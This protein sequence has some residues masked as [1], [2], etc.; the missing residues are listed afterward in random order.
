MKKTLLWSCSA[1][2]LAA[3]V[4]YA[5]GIKLNTEMDKV[6]H[7]IG[8]NIGTNLN[9][10]EDLNV[11]VLLESIKQAREGKKLQL[12]EDEVSKIMM[13]FQQKM[14]AK[15][16]EMA[17]KQ[18]DENLKV[19]Q[20]YLAANAKKEGVKTTAS[21]L[22]YKVIKAGTGATPKATDTISAHYHGTLIDGTIFDSSYDRGQPASFPVNGVIKGWVEALQLMKVG[23][24]WELTI[25]A[26]LAYGA[27]PR[28]G[29]PIGPNA[30]LNFKIELLSIQ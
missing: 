14:Q 25:P 10:I 9:E 26:E 2:L 19:G 15:Q 3:T 1:A 24:I 21:G 22:Q 6:S 12:P 20:E 28:P 16:M 29:G 8:N 27:N 4:S 5:E 30:V 23:G 17:K 13:A 7:I 11:D 18:A